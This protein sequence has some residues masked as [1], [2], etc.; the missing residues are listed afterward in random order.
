[1][2]ERVLPHNLDAERS[3]LGAMLIDNAVISTA[4]EFV[5]AAQFF[6]DAH[7]VIYATILE[8]V[9]RGA[10]ADL[11]SLCDALR[12]KQVLEDVGGPAY[13]AS[14][15][16]GVPRSTNVDHY[17]RV[18]RRDWQYR[19][20]ITDAN[21]LAAA[22][23]E[24]DDDP[25]SL[26]A[27]ADTKLG[28]IVTSTAGQGFTPLSELSSDAFSTIERLHQYRGQLS[29]VPSGLVD[30][31]KL[32]TGF[33]PGDLIVLAARPSVGKTALALNFARNAAGAG[34]VV[35]I[36]SLEMSKKSLFMRLLTSE[37]KVDN[38]RL[39]MGYL[40]EK[41]F[42][43]LAVGLD[44]LCGGSLSIF[45][46]D[47][48]NTLP[49]VRNRARKLAADNGLNLLIIDYM[50][51]MESGGRHENRNVEVAAL[52]RGLK[53]LAKELAIPIIVLS[54]LSRAPEARSDKRPMLSDLRDSGSIEQDA[55]VVMLCYREEM[56]QDDADEGV[57]EV[58]IAKQREGPTGTVKLRF[59][60]EF[61]RFDNY[62]PD[63]HPIE[64][65]ARLADAPGA[66]IGSPTT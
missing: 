40:A 30:I 7:R 38:Q 11:V 51:L 46:D 26:L 2:S 48:A 37:S 27:V 9:E 28:S 59:F 3:V 55:D 14:L 29:G 57:T 34:A 58:D 43:R 32:T 21:A 63:E 8:I 60:K 15:V 54:Q 24:Q 64:A 50:Q 53:K 4:N 61:S 20:I 17:A 36:N 42:A 12:V 18:V 22:A 45:I 44:T 35:G 56:Y 25:S 19:Q 39:R 41:D 66:A 31:D 33:Q 5:Q 65:R 1:M 49:A 16:D 10:P 62:R 47:D 23:Y 13:I 52:S 6:R